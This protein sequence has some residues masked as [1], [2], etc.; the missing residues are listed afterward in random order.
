MPLENLP[1]S[2]EAT[3]VVIDSLLDPDAIAKTY[4]DVHNQHRSAWTWELELRPWL[5]KF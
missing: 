4:L 2:D 5:E 1:P 3:G